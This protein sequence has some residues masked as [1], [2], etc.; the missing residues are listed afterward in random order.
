MQKM[1]A[2]QLKA[3][4]AGTTLK[5]GMPTGS[6]SERGIAYLPDGKMA[7]A[8]SVTGA[9]AAARSEAFRFVENRNDQRIYERI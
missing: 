9:E 5:I 7:K 4:P 1:N 6:V 3:T 8:S 2:A